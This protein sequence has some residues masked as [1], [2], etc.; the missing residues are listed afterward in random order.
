M[1][2]TTLE[3]LD[4]LPVGTHIVDTQVSTG[5]TRHEDGWT[6]VPGNISRI[7]SHAFTTAI[8]EGRL[9][10]VDP[11]PEPLAVT[12]TPEQVTEALVGYISEHGF[13][14]RTE[15][16]DL[17]EVM[18]NLGLTVP[19]EPTPVTVQVTG[20]TSV[21]PTDEQVAQWVGGPVDSAG[22]MYSIHW[23]TALTVTKEVRAGDCPCAGV[24][25]EEVDAVLSEQG[26]RVT[27]YGYAP[28]CTSP[29]HID[30]L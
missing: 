24:T 29:A 27:D 1:N 17:Y 9:S 19:T 12:L 11:E 4:A 30:P 20:Q 7:D 6:N 23:T 22:R 3:E 14:S 10:V 13:L 15:K 21:T 25:R 5:W 8:G 26:V 18:T 16:Y 2:I 28:T